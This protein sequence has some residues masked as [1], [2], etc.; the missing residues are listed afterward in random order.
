MN[1]TVRIRDIE[2]YCK[3]VGYSRPLCAAISAY[4]SGRRALAEV[5]EH[6]P[7]DWATESHFIFPAPDVTSR[8]EL[9][10]LELRMLD[11]Y[12]VLHGVQ[13]F[14]GK[15][16]KSPKA[17]QQAYEHL[18]GM[19][20]PAD[21][22][23]HYLFD[24]PAAH[25][26]F[27]DR[28]FGD[29]NIFGRT[30]QSY[31][32]QYFNSIFPPRQDGY[33]DYLNLSALLLAMDPPQIDLAFQVALHDVAHIGQYA[34]SLLRADAARFTPWVRELAGPPTSASTV[35]EE[36]R[37]DALTTLLETDPLGNLDLALVAAQPTAENP[38]WYYGKMQ[39]AAMK[40][41]LDND[42]ERC[43]S[44][45]ANTAVSGYFPVS[46]YAVDMLVAADFPRAIPTLQFA[47]AKANLYTA[48]TALKELL[49]R[50]WTGCSDFLVTVLGL[51]SKQLRDD[52]AEWLVQNDPAVIADVAPLLAHNSADTR[53][54]AINILARA[55]AW[56]E[57]HR[58]RE[59]L[60][61]RL[62]QEKVARVRAALIDAIG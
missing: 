4:L 61:A 27:D 30:A 53:L 39:I 8:D 24:M 1:D 59:L 34:K 17:F 45:V 50:R 13:W 47:V 7:P 19:N 55:A 15:I 54:T 16:V 32:P 62:E 58:V 26:W 36:V 25:W 37:L 56:H 21:S 49:R 41:L 31:L 46:Q 60:A 2:A 11:L 42:R 20:T 3:K 14:L 43:W 38:G 6:V 52:A 35:S 40:S 10:A 22:M 44:L 51:R 5:A 28:G 48:Q 9:D 33:Y 18:L 23:L 12:T 29:L 57:L